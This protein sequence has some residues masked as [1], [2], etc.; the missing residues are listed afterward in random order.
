MI[1]REIHLGLVQGQL[2]FR[3]RTILTD[4][5]SPWSNPIGVDL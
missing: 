2:G 5:V 3:L 1:N 4:S